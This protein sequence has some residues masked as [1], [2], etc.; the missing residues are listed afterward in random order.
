MTYSGHELE[1]TFAKNRCSIAHRVI[2]SDLVLVQCN[3]LRR[4]WSSVREGAA[5]RIVIM[6]RCELPSVVRGIAPDHTGY[7]LQ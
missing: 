3:S 4:C 1:F 2:G 7:I 5:S 6:G